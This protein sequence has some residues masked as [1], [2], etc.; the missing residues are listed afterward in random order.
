[1]QGM[2]PI[3]HWRLMTPKSVVSVGE[4]QVTVEATATPP[5]LAARESSPGAVSL[6]SSVS[7]GV[8]AAAALAF[9]QDDALRRRRPKF[10]AD[11]PAIY[12]EHAASPA[13][14][15]RRKR[16]RQKPAGEPSPEPPARDTVEQPRR[17]RQHRLQ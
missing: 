4:S 3:N 10:T 2:F 16:H 9:R 11:A 14:P 12:E 6:D 8:A 1:M 13:P 7:D 15:Q 17:R 5:V